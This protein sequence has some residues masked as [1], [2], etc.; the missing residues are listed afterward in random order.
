MT[1]QHLVVEVQI[2]G[3]DP[4]NPGNPHVRLKTNGATQ[5]PFDCR[6]LE[7]G[8]KLH[9]WGKEGWELVAAFRLP[10]PLAVRGYPLIERYF[11]KQ[12]SL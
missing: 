10:Q 9:E 6:Y 3:N 4:E 8:A 1:W 2:L 12:S 7:I 11:L 5:V